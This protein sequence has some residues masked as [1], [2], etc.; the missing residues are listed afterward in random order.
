MQQD[1]QQQLAA[2]QEKRSEAESRAA[3]AEADTQTAKGTA[4]AAE[5]RCATETALWRERAEEAVA[6]LRKLAAE[7]NTTIGAAET[8]C[9]RGFQ[10]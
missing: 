8:S 7:R 4:A 10:C 1:A 3:A 2:V 5:S 6:E 9:W